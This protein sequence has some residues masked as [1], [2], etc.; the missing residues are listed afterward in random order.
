VRRGAR[1]VILYLWRPEFGHALN[2]VPFDLSCYHIDDEYSFSETEISLDTAEKELIQK[3]DQVFIH[4][5]RLM[6]RKGSINTSTVLIPNGVDFAAYSSPAACPSDL[7]SIPRPI[8][9]YTG[10]LKKWL[11][12]PLILE[13]ATRHPEWS[14]VFVG[15]VAPHQE[16]ESAIQKLRS[17]RNVYFL[18]SK[19]INELAAYPQH[20]DV[21]TMPYRLDGYTNN[22]YPMK[23][24]EYLASGTPVVGSPIRSLVDFSHIIGLAEGAQQWSEQLAQALQ[25]AARTA[26]VSRAR[27]D[28]A[29][30]YDWEKLANRIAQTM[31]QRLSYANGAATSAKQTEQSKADDHDMPHLMQ[32]LKSIVPR[33]VRVSV[34]R[35]AQDHL[36]SSALRAIAAMAPKE[37]PSHDLLAQLRAGWGNEG[38]SGRTAYLEEVVKWAAITPGPVLECGSG[39]TTLLLG[40]YAGS[41]G[42]PVWSLEHD[43]A[44][45]QETAKMLHRYSIPGVELCRAPLSNYGDFAWYSPPLGR[46]PAGFSFVVC[47]GPPERTTR[48]RRYGLLPVMSERLVADCVILV[49]DV[50]LAAES[51]LYLW[52]TQRPSMIKILK[53]DE[54]Q[55]FGLMFLG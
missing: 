5:P 29:R 49:D 6:E 14:F 10:F 36:F 25:P 26:S 31:R 16:I 46:M 37:I 33:I 43:A 15:P 11:D 8:V 28:V 38:W 19:L 32:E 40:L 44:W 3:V 30:E 53:A 50:D 52:K 42:V 1:N 21:C 51:V 22:I 23:L 54:S 4:S 35:Y 13:L 17:L 27:Q 55:S 41:R 48:G 9:G 20:F 39:L 34:K 47:D 18:G 2:F 24:H 45:H 12:W 7:E